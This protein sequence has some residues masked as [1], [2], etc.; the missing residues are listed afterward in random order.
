MG[1]SCIN[2]H[3]PVGVE[4]GE[5]PFHVSDVDAEGPAE[6]WCPQCFVHHR[7]P[8]EPERFL[9]YDGIGRGGFRATMCTNPKCG[10][11]AVDPG[12]GRCMHCGCHALIELPARGASV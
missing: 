8:L 7:A 6:T 3:H 9:T 2:C 1:A 5:I 10:L 12:I 4:E 11:K